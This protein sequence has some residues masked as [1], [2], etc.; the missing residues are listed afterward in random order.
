M[1]TWTSRF[2]TVA[3][4]AATVMLAACGGRLATGGGGNGSPPQ[5]STAVTRD[6][7][8]IAGP[9]GFCVDP[10][11]TRDDGVTG[12][13]LMGNCAAISESSGAGQPEIPALLTASV[14]DAAESGS[15]RESIPTLAEFFRSEDGRR[16]L[17]RSQNADSVEVLDSFHQGDIYFLQARDTSED[18][19][20]G[21]GQEYWRA[22]MDV[23]PRIATLSVLR[24]QDR[25]LSSE[26][27]LDLLRGFTAAV[28]AANAPG[29]PAVAVASR[30]AP[31]A[32]PSVA[33]PPRQTS[34]PPRGTV[35]NRGN[36]QLG[37]V[38]LFRRIFN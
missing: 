6:A 34:A 3:A 15:L 30:P 36:R 17:S 21:V 29:A 23:G 2:G 38:G 35:L 10:T 27:S 32:V 19:M 24:V 18:A 11:A 12:F 25:E 33:P 8:V 16:L 20:F 4:L 9:D 5:Y 14:S 7:V 26:A 13:V 28:T 1:S 22:Y 37:N 31:S